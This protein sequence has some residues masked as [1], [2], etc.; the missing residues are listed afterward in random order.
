MDDGN[1]KKFENFLAWL[2]PNRDL[3]ATRYVT[4]RDGL[5]KYFSRKTCRGDFNCPHAE[6]LA[7]ETLDRVISKMD[8]VALNNGAEP[9]RRIY[10]FAKYLRLE[11]HRQPQIKPFPSD[12]VERPSR[13]SDEAIEK[14]AEFR[15][16]DEC[17][18][19]LLF[20]DQRLVTE[21]FGH[22]GK[23]RSRRRQ[24]QADDLGITL[25]NLRTTACRLR[26]KLEEC[27]KN[28]LKK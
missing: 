8:E 21:Y 13:K 28:C 19:E 1:R 16:C 27:L 7:D 4:I 9:E 5:V 22:S 26:K 25:S 17:L 6:E 10:A 15:C 12:F 14:E 18:G 2:N 24:Q 3:A 11:H 20:K 23:E